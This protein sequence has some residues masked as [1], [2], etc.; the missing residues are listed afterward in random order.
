MQLDD[1]CSS[2]LLP[3]TIF[4][5]CPL[6]KIQLLRKCLPYR[7]PTVQRVSPECYYG[8]V[9]WIRTSY[10]YKPGH[11]L[12]VSKKGRY[13]GD[14]AVVT[15]H[16]PSDSWV[17]VA[18]VP[19]EK[20]SSKRKRSSVKDAARLFVAED[21]TRAHFRVPS[22]GHDGVAMIGGRGFK[23]GLEFM[24]LSLYEVAEEPTPPID[25]ILSLMEIPD[26]TDVM[27]LAITRSFKRLWNSGIKVHAV[28]GDLEGSDG[29]VLSLSGSLATVQFGGLAP[30]LYA[31][32]DLERCFQIGDEVQVVWGPHAGKHGVIILFEDGTEHSCTAVIATV[33]DTGE[34]VSP[35]EFLR[36]LTKASHFR[37]YHASTSALQD[38]SVTFNHFRMLFRHI[39]PFGIVNVMQMKPLC[40]PTSLLMNGLLLSTDLI[41]VAGAVL[42]LAMIAA[43]PLQQSILHRRLSSSRKNMYFWS[44]KFFM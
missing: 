34:M 3:R 8:A 23:Y 42:N 33:D 31:I 10:Q 38:N 2:E 22:E 37:Q 14:L 12:R 25:Q 28:C 9:R 30:V 24:V 29:L 40:Q 19:R 39:I 41:R 13:N 6:E 36:H 32:D 4:L 15:C 43:W 27:T 5:S 16:R 35:L 21:Y 20:S 1:W 17:T 7:I 44:S 11:L 18:C 26:L